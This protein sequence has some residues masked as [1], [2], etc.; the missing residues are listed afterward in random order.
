MMSSLAQSTTRNPFNWF[1]AGPQVAQSRR[2]RQE[3]RVHGAAGRL[4]G[5]GR[6]IR[7]TKHRPPHK[8]GRQQIGRTRTYSLRPRAGNDAKR[9]PCAA[10]ARRCPKSANDSTNADPNATRGSLRPEARPRYSPKRGNS[11]LWNLTMA[12]SARAGAAAVRPR[13]NSPIAKASLFISTPHVEPSA[14]RPNV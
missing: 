2:R 11:R 4:I 5:T 6:W 7:Q 9:Q 13:A 14:A 1:R 3:T 10:Y 8:G 12:K